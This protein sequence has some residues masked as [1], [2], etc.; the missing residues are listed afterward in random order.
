MVVLSTEPNLEA[1]PYNVGFYLSG[2][3]GLK[4]TGITDLKVIFLR[5]DGGLGSG[6]QPLSQTQI[7]FTRTVMIKLPCVQLTRS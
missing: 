6:S 7:C 2:H 4:G 1:S 3:S 5:K